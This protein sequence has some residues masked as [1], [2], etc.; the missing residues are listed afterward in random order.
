MNYATSAVED[1]LSGE[2]RLK[3]LSPREVMVMEYTLH[4]YN[5]REI[6]VALGITKGTVAVHLI[7]ARAKLQVHGKGGKTIVNRGLT[8]SPSQNGR[9]HGQSWVLKPT[10]DVHESAQ[11]MVHQYGL[12]CNRATWQRQHHDPQ[13]KGTP[14][15]LL[16]L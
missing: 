12:S 1:A 5:N 6:A 8:D 3:P 2:A 13:S 4:G 16:T 15:S 11:R 14:L 7:A 9:I 10:G